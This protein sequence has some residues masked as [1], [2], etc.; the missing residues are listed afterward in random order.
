MTAPVHRD[1]L[2]RLIVATGRQLARRPYLSAS[3]AVHAGLLGLLYAFGSYQLALSQRAADAV[4]VASSLR[5]TR[6]ASTAKRLQDLRTIKELLE[7]SAGREEAGTEAAQ[8][9]EAPPQ[10]PQEA[11][12]RARELAQAIDKLDQEMRAEEL[13]K[14]TGS[15]KPPPA[16]AQATGDAAS[17]PAAEA[18]QAAGPPGGSGASAPVTAEAVAGEVAALEAKARETLA[19]RLKRL[20]ARAEGMQVARPIRPRPP[21]CWTRCTTARTSA[22]SAG[23]T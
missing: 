15:P 13:A 14:L 5:A 6:E 12:E 18:V 20:E 1:P 10:T 22:C 4:E 23:A 8:A 21:C 16:E 9:F 11:L 7:Q 2:Q 17:A 3:V 19:R